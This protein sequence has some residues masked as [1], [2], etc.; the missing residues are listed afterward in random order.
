MGGE[1]D[2]MSLQQKEIANTQFYIPPMILTSLVHYAEQQ[3]WQYDNWFAAQNLDLE[4]I[5]QGHGFVG[6]SELCEVIHLAVKDTQQQNLGLLLGSSEG[7]ISIGILGFAMQACKTVAEA[8]ETALHYHPIS[9]SVLDLG[10][11]LGENSIYLAKKCFIVTAVEFAESGIN[12][13]M[14]SAKKKNLKITPVLGDVTDPKILDRLGRFDNIIS[15]NLLQFLYQTQVDYL[16]SWMQSHT[17][18]GGYNVIATFVA[19]NVEE[20]QRLIKERSEERENSGYYIRY[21]FSPNELKERYNGWLMKPRD[22][23]EFWTA[24]EY[25]NGRWPKHR[26]GQLIAQKPLDS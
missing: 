11:G 19:R 22:Y 2:F 9:G 12:K 4:Q 15:L 10:S 20:K 24:E 25:N 13:M 6:F 21:L 1:A 23:K 18:P 16:I 5:R 3:H 7:Q 17:N 14:E 8:L 26:V